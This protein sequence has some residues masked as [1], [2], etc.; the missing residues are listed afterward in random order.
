MPIQAQDAGVN[1]KNRKNRKVVI[2]IKQQ[3]A[4]GS[5]VPVQLPAGLGQAQDPKSVFKAQFN[6]DKKEYNPH[7]RNPPELSNNLITDLIREFHQNRISDQNMSS[8]IQGMG[9]DPSIVEKLNQSKQSPPQPKHEASDRLNQPSPL[10]DRHQESPSRNQKYKT[11]KR[12][13][14]NTKARQNHEL[15][16]KMTRAIL[17]QQQQNYESSR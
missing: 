10:S 7:A 14:E 5:M 4:D 13:R 11:P 1:P 3:A 16:E 8:I 12:E 6:V 17:A 15:S 2:T 9:L